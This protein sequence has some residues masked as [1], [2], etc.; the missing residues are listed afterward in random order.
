[1]AWSSTS[2]TRI[3]AAAVPPLPL[4]ELAAAGSTRPAS[5]TSYDPNSRAHT[6]GG[7]WSA[8]ACRP[9]QAGCKSER[10]A[11]RTNRRLCER[12]PAGSRNRSALGPTVAAA[13]VRYLTVTVLAAD[14]L[15][16]PRCATR[17]RSLYLPFLA[18]AF[19][20]RRVGAAR[21]EVGRGAVLP[22][23]GRRQ[24]VLQRGLHGVVGRRASAP[25]TVMVLPAVAS[26]RSR[27]GQRRAVAQRRGGAD[28]GAV[29][30]RTPARPRD[31][32]DHD[33]E[34]EL[35]SSWSSL[36]R[37]RGVRGSLAVSDPQYNTWGC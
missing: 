36:I 1:M 32:Q 21:R 10:I 13:D 16:A 30:P 8:S 28:A 34:R 27:D 17:T 25:V 26:C 11:R 24:L 33:G 35:T 29:T 12:S 14:V 4:A 19:H 6:L 2:R 5:G 18:G 23:G 37:Q 9:C 3:S 31:G 22:L 15:D 20:F 7:Q